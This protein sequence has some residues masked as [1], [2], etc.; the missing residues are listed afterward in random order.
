ML[1]PNS[2]TRVLYTWHL[3]VKNMTSAL[4]EVSICWRRLSPSLNFCSP[5]M[6]RDLGVIF[7]KYPSLDRNTV[8]G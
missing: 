2:D 8:T 5:L 7:L 1:S 4:L 6:R 3:S